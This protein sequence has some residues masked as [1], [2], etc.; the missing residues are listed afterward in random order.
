M[1][2]LLHS[3]AALVLCLFQ[4]VAVPHN[5]GWVT[6][7]AGVLTSA[8]EQALEKLC[9]SYRA[10]S[11]QEIAVLIVPN[12]AGQPIERLAL[13]VA[14]EWKIGRAGVDDGALLVVAKDD[15][16]LRI[17]V[18][19]GL[20]G[21]LTDSVSGRIIRNVIVPSFKAGDFYGGVRG[22]LEAMH[23]ALGGKY[24]D[25]PPRKHAA[26]D[27][28]G[29]AFTVV[30]ILL[31]IVFGV[32]GRRHRRGYGGFG[33][34]FIGG[35]GGGLGDGGGGGFSGGGFGGFGGG[36]GFSGGGSSGGW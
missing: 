28:I 24:V 11:G 29:A 22:G 9:E 7:T 17:E 3:L 32:L 19:R 12:L 14:R 5:D 8:Q 35:F 34:P 13:E 16:K 6:D 20:E 23:A 36:G 4:G 26:G 2:T 18:G 25:P 10:G 30:F 31:M 27:A 21:T 33:G 1:P 15:R